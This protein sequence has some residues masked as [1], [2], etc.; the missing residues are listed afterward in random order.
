MIVLL[1]QSHGLDDQAPVDTIQVGSWLSVPWLAAFLVKYTTYNESTP[2]TVIVDGQ[3]TI[4]SHLYN[5][6]GSANAVYLYA[7]SLGK[8]KMVASKKIEVSNHILKL[9]TTGL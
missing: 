8:S 2:L 3:A 9:K 1:L 5:H 4:N 6:A 7:V